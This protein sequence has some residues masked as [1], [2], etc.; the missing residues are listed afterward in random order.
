MNCY[1]AIDVM[2]DPHRVWLARRLPEAGE[3][4]ARISARL[5]TERQHLAEPVGLL[6]VPA[7]LAL[8]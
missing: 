7:H 8:P 3:P 2:G 1:E 4:I 5:S 6:Y